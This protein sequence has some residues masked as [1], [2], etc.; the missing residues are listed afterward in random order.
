M[1]ISL[2]VLSFGSS[3]YAFQYN[4][5]TYYSQQASLEKTCSAPFYTN[6]GRDCVQNCR[7]A[8]WNS[9]TGMAW[10][11]VSVW[12]GY[13]YQWQYVQQ[14]GTWWSYQWVNTVQYAHPS[15]CYRGRHPYTPR[16]PRH[17]PPRRRW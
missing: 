6:Y 1:F 9:H 7:V 4:T 17:I 3:A 16:R 5:G 14:Y 11:Y 2:F 15:A 8:R 13:G 10:G 12:T